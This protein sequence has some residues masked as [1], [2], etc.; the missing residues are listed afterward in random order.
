ME[1]EEIVSNVITKRA[2]ISRDINLIIRHLNDNDWKVRK[3]GLE[4]L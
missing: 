3:D 1:E 2:D 4:K